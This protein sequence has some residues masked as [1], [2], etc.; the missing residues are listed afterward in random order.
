MNVA[1][2]LK[3]HGKDYTVTKITADGSYSGTDGTFIPGS[4]ATS[5]VRGSLQPATPDDLLSIPEGDRTKEAYRFYSVI[6]LQNADIAK[7]RKGDR[8][9]VSSAPFEVKSVEHWPNHGKAVIV[10]VNTNAN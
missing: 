9:S 6:P 2:M 8:V 3:R 7:L 10:R 5:T 4:S 1:G